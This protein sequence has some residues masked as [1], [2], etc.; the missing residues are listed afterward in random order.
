[1]LFG[2]VAIADVPMDEDDPVLDAC[3]VGAVAGVRQEVVDDDVI[4]RIPLAPVVDEVGADEPGSTGD[5]QPHEA[6]RLA[7]HLGV[8]V[9]DTLAP[10]WEQRRVLPLA[11]EHGVRWPRCGPSELLGRDPADPACAA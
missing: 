1:R 2:E 6:G 4:V 9:S 10:V 3:Q 7:A 11:A 8:T 5:E